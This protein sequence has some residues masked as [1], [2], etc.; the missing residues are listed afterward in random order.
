MGRKPANGVS[1][2]WT[3]ENNRILVAQHVKEITDYGQLARRR[4]MLS[5]VDLLRS[6]LQKLTVLADKWSKM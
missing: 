5:A 3:D 2:E 1:A 6:A 4:C